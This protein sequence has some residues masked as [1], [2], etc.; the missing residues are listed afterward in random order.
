M[1]TTIHSQ[2]IP[3]ISFKKITIYCELMFLFNR[4]DYSFASKTLIL[5]S[6]RCLKSLIQQVFTRRLLVLSLSYPLSYQINIRRYRQL[7][8]AVFRKSWYIIYRFQI[9]YCNPIS[10][11][12]PFKATLSLLCFVKYYLYWVLRCFTLIDILSTYLQ[13]VFINISCSYFI[14]NDNVREFLI[15]GLFI[16]TDWQLNYSELY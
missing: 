12:L 11:Q 13:H 16:S 6:E 2:N 4:N 3:R 10:L 9:I 8:S 7:F 1:F 15:I 5:V 14:S